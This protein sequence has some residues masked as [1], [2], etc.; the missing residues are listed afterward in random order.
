MKILD[1]GCNGKKYDSGN[2]EDIVIG[3]DIQQFP[4]VDVI[5]DMEESP[6]PFDDESF[7]M[8]YSGHSLEHVR[9]RLQL[10][11]DVWRI[12]KPGGTFEVIV[13]HHTN[14]IGKTV[15]HYG[16]FGMHA[17]DLFLP[18]KKE[19]YI[20]GRFDIVE[21]KIKLVQPLGFLE[22][23]ANRFPDF[24]EWRLAAFM[25]AVEVHFKLKKV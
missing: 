18:D 15:D 20:R 25:P 12:L 17:F 21:R 2:P 11:D 13:P 3:L 1:L 4:D 16:F 14:P 9:N 10:L 8:V 22:P 7:D 24:Y 6:L 23:I 5:H 19:K